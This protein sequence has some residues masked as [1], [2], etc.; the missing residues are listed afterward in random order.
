MR[1]LRAFYLMICLLF[2]N[3]LTVACKFPDNTLDLKDIKNYKLEKIKFGQTTI[4]EFASLVGIKPDYTIENVDI[5]NTVP[6][7]NIVFKKIRVGFKNKKLDW[8]E[9]YL[10]GDIKLSKI[11]DIY[12]KPD[13][14]NR[15]YSKLFD[16]Y[17]Y[18]FFNISTD[19]QHKYARTITIFDLP[20]SN[21]ESIIDLSPFIPKWQDIKKRSIMGLKPG[22]SLESDF[23]DLHP[24]LSAINNNDFSV[25]VL[26][27]ELGK[28]KSQYESI[29]IVFI[30]GLLNWIYIVPAR[31]NLIQA[32]GVWGKEYKIETINKKYDLY[33]FDGIIAVVDK[34]N[35]K[36]AKIGVITDK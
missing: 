12:G 16:Y 27:R 7:D 33:D 15:S 8:I 2:L 5:Y 10:N 20:E 11:T 36:V 24:E 3:L 19:K 17:D 30:N 22:Y 23:N 1:K 13:N 29:E 9:F 6:F 14:I 28:A 4:D 26:D 31:M 25:Y 32:I 34:V 18:K 35:N 21:A